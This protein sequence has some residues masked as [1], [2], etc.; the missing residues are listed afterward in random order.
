ML[1]KDI[2]ELVPLERRITPLT[3]G[4]L[5]SLTVRQVREANS[6][7]NDN[8]KKMF[9]REYVLTRDAKAS[10]LK[11]GYASHYG[12]QL[13]SDKKVQKYMQELTN[14]AGTEE[15]ANVQEAL[16]QLT[17]IVRGDAVDYA[18]TKDGEVF[19]L[20]AQI[21]DRVKCLDILTKCQGLQQNN[22]KVSG[23]IENINVVAEP[24]V[25]PIVHEINMEDIEFIDIDDLLD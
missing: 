16:M 17:S 2:Y 3:E 9:A 15:I 12:Y 11:C 13:L 10:A 1:S 8:K 21:K 5:D 18:Y 22:L 24:E 6:I 25:S 14:L 4:E 19:E 23:Q 20:P 7:I